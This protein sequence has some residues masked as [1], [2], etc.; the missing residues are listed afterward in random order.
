LGYLPVRATPV[1]LSKRVWTLTAS[2]GLPLP[3]DAQ[4]HA[5][6]RASFDAIVSRFGV[7]FFDDSMHAFTNL[8]SERLLLRLRQNSHC[9][10]RGNDF[11]DF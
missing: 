7:M 2:I 9:F 10:Q 11:I 8:R 3:P 1:K 5:F 4:T 6:E